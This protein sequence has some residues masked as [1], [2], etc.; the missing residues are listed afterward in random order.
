MWS[1]CDGCGGRGY[2]EC[3]YC[4]GSGCKHCD[5]GEVEC[6][7]CE[8]NGETVA[9]MTTN[10]PSINI[11]PNVTVSCRF[12]QTHLWYDA[13]RDIFCH[14]PPPDWIAAWNIQQCPAYGKEFKLTIP[15]MAIKE[16]A[17]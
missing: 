1:I 5:K 11:T 14:Y 4:D 10:N 3:S 15:G 6:I 8:G 12:C 13:D 16:V 7:D 9:D 17:R 2:V